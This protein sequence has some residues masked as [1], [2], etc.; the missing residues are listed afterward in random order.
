QLPAKA[1]GA[2]ETADTIKTIGLSTGGIGGLIF[3]AKK[4]WDLFKPLKSVP[5]ELLASVSA[6]TDTKDLD[7]Q[8]SFRYRFANE[9]ATFCDVLRWPPHPG[10]VIFVDDLDRCAPRQTVDVLEAINF[11]TSAGKCF[12]ILGIDES[13]V[14]AA[15]ADIY[16][17]MTLK[18]EFVDGA[19]GKGDDPEELGRR[20][21]RDLIQFSSNYLEKLIH[22]IVP[23]PRSKKETVEVLLGLAA[24]PRPLA[25]QQWWQT[26]RKSAYEFV[27]TIV[28]VAFL[29]AAAWLSVNLAT[30]ALIT[31]AAT[32]KADEIVAT[33]TP[34]AANSTGAQPAPNI[35]QGP[36][37]ATTPKN[38]MTTSQL[39]SD[40]LLSVDPLGTVP[41]SALVLVFVLSIAMVAMLFV[42]RLFP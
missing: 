26:M 13:K 24:G 16:K 11:V 20:R 36:P 8:L 41:P 17:D 38:F 30:R 42:P 6:R 32:P 14:K 12:V 7:Q 10:L 1:A 28:A 19:A 37:A 25:S 4:L 21:V 34:P 40:G 39:T 2:Q 3:S 15:V 35:A 9:F 5:A 18:L 31:Y 22:L 23:V 27:G 33:G 29:A